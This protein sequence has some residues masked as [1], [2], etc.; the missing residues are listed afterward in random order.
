M[1]TDTMHE[2]PEHASSRGVQAVPLSRPLHWLRLGWSDLMYHQKASFAYG[3]LVTAMGAVILVFGRHP[4]FIAATITGFLLV[5]PVLAAG[6]CELSRRRARGESVNFDA[7]LQVLERNRASL[8]SFAGLLLLIGW[9]WL[10]LSTL[11]LR[12][13]F[14]GAAPDVGTSM[15]AN[16]VAEISMGQA[17]A[18]VIAGGVLALATFVMSVI[19]VPMLIDRPETSAYDAI[20]A[21]MKAAL[22]HIPLMLFWGVLIVAL[23]AIGFGTLLLGFIVIFPLLGHATWHAYED[24]AQ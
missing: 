14:G 4:Y 6:L 9:L 16:T 24:L 19:T 3:V 1:H 18:Y 2:A 13:G 23:A 21:S 7:S 20:Y 10:L 12:W 5:G 22:S 15:W 8:L 11:I 17:V